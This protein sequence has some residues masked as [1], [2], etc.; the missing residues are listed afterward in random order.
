LAV[1]SG[2]LPRVYTVAATG[3]LLGILVGI[4]PYAVFILII[5]GIFVSILRLLL[6]RGSRT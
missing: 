1:N 3:G 2:K 4:L 6:R 5:F